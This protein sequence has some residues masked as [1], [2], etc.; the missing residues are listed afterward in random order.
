MDINNIQNNTIN[1]N[2]NF[3]YLYESVSVIQKITQQ[4]QIEKIIMGTG[5]GAPGIV[6][7]D[8]LRKINSD[9]KIFYI[10]TDLLFQETYD[11]KDK[12]EEYYNIKFTRLSTNVSIKEQKELHGDKLWKTDPN[13]CCN[14][15]KVIPLK[16]ALKDFDVWI[17]GIRKF[18]TQMRKNSKIIDYDELYNVTKVNPLINWT[19]DQIWEYIR[20]KNIPYN[21]LHDKG[22]PSL[23]CVHC[24]TSVKKGENH[25]AGRWR[26]KNKTEC[27]LHFGYKNGK[28]QALRNGDKNN[29]SK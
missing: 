14:I 15:R 1:E 20:I 26:N 8:I 23:G 9:I 4:F 11:L 21:K 29:E 7:I 2:N 28:V 18:Q 19:H 27:G 10:D 17:T 12:L 22:Y 13:L 25:R 16:N 5:F 3:P 6:L 24:T